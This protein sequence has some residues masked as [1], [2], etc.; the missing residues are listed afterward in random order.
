MQVAALGPSLAHQHSQRPVELGQAHGPCRDCQAVGSLHTW[1]VP[2]PSAALH[3]RLCISQVCHVRAWR[4][5]SLV[6]AVEGDAA[7]LSTGSVPLHVLVQHVKYCALTC[8]QQSPQSNVISRHSKPA[9]RH[10]QTLHLAAGSSKQ[11]TVLGHKLHQACGA[12]WSIPVPAQ[13]KEQVVRPHCQV[14]HVALACKVPPPC[15]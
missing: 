2:L 6:M 7:C 10:V 4:M 15:T 11:L 8:K 1:Q 13:G 14:I 5:V 3:C 9:A 12:A